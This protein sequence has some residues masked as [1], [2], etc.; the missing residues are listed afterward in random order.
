MTVPPLVQQTLI[1]TTGQPLEAVNRTIMAE[2]VSQGAT[3]EVA[4]RMMNLS[5]Q[6]GADLWASIANRLGEAVE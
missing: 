1:R 5:P 2:C 4:A 6:E 3:P